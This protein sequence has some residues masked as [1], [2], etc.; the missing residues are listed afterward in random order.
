M[1]AFIA[2]IIIGGEG[3]KMAVGGHGVDKVAE[4]LRLEQVKVEK[5]DDDV[6]ISGY[7]PKE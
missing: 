4:A 5:I 6:M 7:V 2:P 3:A 1:V